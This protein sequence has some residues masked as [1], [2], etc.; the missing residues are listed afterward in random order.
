[1]ARLYKRGGWYYAH[2]GRVPGRP[3]VGPVRV[4]LRTKRAREA[5]AMMAELLAAR[6]TGTIPGM[7]RTARRKVTLEQAIKAHDDYAFKHCAPRSRARYACAGRKLIEYF[8]K[9]RKVATID[10]QA[11][12]DYV[13]D[14][15]RKLKPN[16]VNSE[17]I[18][19]L[20]IMR[21]QEIAGNIARMPRIKFVRVPKQDGKPI[22]S[23]E[24]LEKVMGPAPEWLRVLLLTGYYTGG[25]RTEMLSLRWAHDVDFE[26]GEIV[27]TITK[28]NEIRRVPTGKVLLSALRAWRLKCQS[29]WVFPHEKDATRHI[30]HNVDRDL[31][32]AIEAAGITERWTLHRL[33][34]TFI[35]NLFRRGE[36]VALVMQLTG[37]SNPNV[38]IKTYAHVMAGDTQRAV[39]GLPE[40]EIPAEETQSGHNRARRRRKPLAE[41]V[42]IG[43]NH[44]H[45][46]GHRL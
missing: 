28:D 16:S 13:T 15:A 35:T 3:T 17:I 39:A 40:I 6:S 31:A 8:G 5:E 21:Q 11:F 46:R 20:S 9:D 19:I 44:G 41:V 22:V 1:M 30:G 18:A 34:H 32:D 10:D 36:S 23:K 45:N 12:A 42:G 26:M 29:E 38:L 33:R 2:L 37:H 4:A 27:Y 43:A 24:E 7:L 25:R 14:R